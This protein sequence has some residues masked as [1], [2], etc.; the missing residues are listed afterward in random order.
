[1]SFAVNVLILFLFL[2]PGIAFRFS[3]QKSDS[4]QLTIDS[5]IIS[6]FALMIFM[7]LIFHALGMFIVESPFIDKEVQFRE[8]YKLL[9]G[10]KDMDFSLL[11]KSYYFFILYITILSSLG[12]FI[13]GQLKK[14]VLKH[15]WDKKTRL[16]SPSSDWDYLLSGR[17]NNISKKDFIVVDALVESSEG[18]MIYV[19]I[20]AKYFL[21][22]DK[23]LDRIYLQGAIRRKLSNDA[24]LPQESE[25]TDLSN[26]KAIYAHYGVAFDERYYELP[27]DYLVLP[28]GQIKNLNVSFRTFDEVS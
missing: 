4:F 10:E 19:G 20:L 26:H 25:I 13:G 8:V 1:M 14:W 24:K 18:D 17:I 6:E 28:F 15:N 21:N 23:S 2:S 16:L 9:L 3:F 11:K 7:S 12:Y 22:K 5:S 27:G